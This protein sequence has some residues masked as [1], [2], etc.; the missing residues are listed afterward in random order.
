[1]PK[2][3]FVRP[4]GME[5]GDFVTWQGWAYVLRGLEPMSVPDRQVELEDPESGERLF[6]P[7]EEVSERSDG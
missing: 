2:P 7:L 5:I 4:C 3:A 1:M 6:A